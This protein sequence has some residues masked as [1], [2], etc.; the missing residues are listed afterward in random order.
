MLI[1]PPSPDWGELSTSIPFEIARQKKRNPRE[2][3]EELYT[4]IKVSQELIET[5]EV[6]GKGYI[7]FKINFNKIATQILQ[8]ALEE[9]ISYG[10][11]E[12]T[13]PLTIIVE[14]TSVNPVHPIH[15]GQ[16]RNPI[17]GDAL[18]RLLE[19][20]NHRIQ[21]HYYVDD[22]GRQSAIL[23]YGY[24]LLGQPSIE[25]KPDTFLGKLYSITSCLVEIQALKKQINLPEGANNDDSIEERQKIQR[26]LDDWIAVAADMKDKYPKMFNQLSTTIM[27]EEDPEQLISRI[28]K[29]YESGDHDTKRLVRTVSDLC[30]EGFQKTL[31]RLDV[32]FDSWDWESDFVWSGRVKTLVDLLRLSSYSRWKD[33]VLELDV[34]RIVDSLD[35]RRKLGI[36]ETYHLPSLTLIRS[37]GTT[38][39]TTR[40]IA[41]SLFKFEEAKRV[42]NVIGAEQRLAQLQ[43]KTAL[44]ALSEKEKADNLI[45]F[46][47]GLIDLPGFRMSS[48]R[49][50]AISLDEVLDEALERA[51]QEV[52]R[53]DTTSTENE[54]RQIA[55]KIGIASIKYA[56]LS[57]EP[58]KTVTF[59]WDRVLNFE[60]NSAPFINYAYTRIL[61]ILKKVEKAIPSK[62]CGEL[63]THPLERRLLLQILKFP[64]VFQG[65]ADKLRP[66]EITHFTNALA[67]LFHEY[68]EK[69]KVIGSKDEATLLARIALIKAVAIVI[70]NA[71]EVLGIELSEKM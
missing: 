28:I 38:L 7:N 39:Y 63:L 19:K 45:H 4:H 54:L 17:L 44:Y 48:R 1:E 3:A 32:T 51:Y 58:I 70:R 65:A 6:A 62:V 47:F 71:M 41:Y 16:A 68:Y 61:S 50:R 34:E 57:V 22:M 59:T 20:R 56:L 35:L 23:V 5:C 9:D 10:Y 15:I 69:V 2:F 31:T 36:S 24:K 21:R 43:L 13:H 33:D 55:E 18:A 67:E 40:D 12:V 25:E 11:I 27:R 49:G 53:R 46:G 30:I 42:I 26:E 14:H 29:L 60:K 37:D 52:R 8:Y 64:E 66:N